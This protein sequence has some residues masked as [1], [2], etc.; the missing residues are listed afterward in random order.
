M[1]QYKKKLQS[2]SH[3]QPS[4]WDEPEFDYEGNEFRVNRVSPS[5]GQESPWSEEEQEFEKS[6]NKQSG[7]RSAKHQSHH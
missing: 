5:Y 2:K 4:G 6:Q 3:Q 7:G 1:N